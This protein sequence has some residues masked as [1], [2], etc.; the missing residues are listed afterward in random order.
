MYDGYTVEEKTCRHCQK[1]YRWKK[2]LDRHLQ[3]CGKDPK[4]GCPFCDHRSKRKENLS[5]HIINRHGNQVI[6]PVDYLIREDT[7]ASQ[8]PI[9]NRN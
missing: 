7:T 5:K 6:G 1:V 4:F 3:E 2:G 9:P 8:S